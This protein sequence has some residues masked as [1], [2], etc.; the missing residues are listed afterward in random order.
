MAW[1]NSKI[2]RQYVADSLN[3]TAAFDLNSDTFKA[4]LFNNS[5]TPDQNVTAALGAYNATSSQWLTANELYETGQWNQGGQA[6]TGVV[7]DTSTSGVVMFDA[8]DTAS[9]ASAD[10]AAVFGCLVYDDTLTTPVADQ[11][12]CFNYFGGTNSVINGT[13]TVV[14]SASGILRFTL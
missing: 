12:V 3:R 4:A 14:W 7:V 13:F 2:L 11:G 9:G 5:I 8:A 6:L 10:L 1:S